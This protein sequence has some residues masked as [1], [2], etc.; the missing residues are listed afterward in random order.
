MVNIKTRDQT[1]KANL[2]LSLEM[3]LWYEELL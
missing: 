3:W 1:K 2:Q